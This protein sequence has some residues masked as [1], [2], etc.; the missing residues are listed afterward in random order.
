[1]R[2]PPHLL[3]VDTLH[4]LFLWT[5]FLVSSIF[6][7]EEP[8]RS[9]IFGPKK[10]LELASKSN[11]SGEAKYLLSSV[12]SEIQ[13]S[14]EQPLWANVPVMTTLWIYF[15]LKLVL[16]CLLSSC[17]TLTHYYFGWDSRHSGAFLAFLGLLMFP[18]VSVSYL[19]PSSRRLS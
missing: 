8:D 6:F 5:I 10:T 12:P 14:K 16:E 11:K 4:R 18:A 9:H 3:Y 19:M 1:M 17:P 15:V 13:S 7:F 2:R